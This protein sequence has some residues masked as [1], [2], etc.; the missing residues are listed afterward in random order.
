[1]PTTRLLETLLQIERSVGRAE[2]TALR[3]LV[4]EAE[5]LVLEM[6]RDSLATLH[7]LRELRERRDVQIPVGSWRAMAQALARAEA[8]KE[9]ARA[10]AVVTISAASSNRAS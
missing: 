9:K 4:M 3:R 10:A 5:G 6:H 7:E 2:P 1:M 8:E